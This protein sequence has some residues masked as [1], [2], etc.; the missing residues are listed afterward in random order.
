MR[1]ALYISQA[2]DAILSAICEGRLQP[3]ERLNQDDH[4][5]RGMS[6]VLHDR[7]RRAGIWDDHE[8]I[9]HAIAGRDAAAAAKQS[10]EPLIGFP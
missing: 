3:G 8:Q 5:R 4:L 2:Y 7:P 10:A 9:L 6:E 1:N